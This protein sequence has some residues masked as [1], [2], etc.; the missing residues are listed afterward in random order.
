MMRCGCGVWQACGGPDE[1]EEGD[2]DD[3]EPVGEPI[4]SDDE[5]EDGWKGSA[6]APKT[7]NEVE[8]LPSEADAAPDVVVEEGDELLPCGRVIT[9]LKQ[10]GTIVVQSDAGV[11][12]LRDDSVLCLRDKRV[13]GKVRTG[14]VW[15]WLLAPQGGCC[16]SD[17]LVFWLLDD[18]AGPRG[19]WP[20]HTAVLHPALQL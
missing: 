18:G 2:E 4:A 3:D 10:E 20:G 15:S 16:V 5:E 19:I 1:D 11:R 6:R 13:L 17:L 14:L 7:H 12:A 8:D 9:V